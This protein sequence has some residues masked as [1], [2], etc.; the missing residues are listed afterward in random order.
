MA[1]T[2]RILLVEDYEPNIKLSGALLKELGYDYDTACSGTEALKKFSASSYA[3]II[4]DVQMPGMD[5]LETTRRL[6]SSEKERYLPETPV[7]GMT[8][9]ATEDDHLLCLKAGMND[10]IFKP[11][12]LKELEE[13]LKKHI[14]SV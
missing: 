3:L 14:L 7:M 4:M 2:K 1:S 9:N 11:F 6:R 8:G 5:G 13:K 10:F 12:R